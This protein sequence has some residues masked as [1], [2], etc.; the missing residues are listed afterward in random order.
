[1]KS[2]NN[3]HAH[4]H[5]NADMY[6]N[7]FD[8]RTLIQSTYDYN[9]CRFIDHFLICQVNRSSRRSASAHMLCSLNAH[10]FKVDIC[11]H[12]Y[13][14]VCSM[15]SSTILLYFLW[16]SLSS[17]ID[18]S[19]LTYPPFLVVY[20]R[21]FTYTH[22][23]HIH[24]NIFKYLITLCGERLLK[25]LIC[26]HMHIYIYVATH[27]QTG[28]HICFGVYGVK[29]TQIQNYSYTVKKNYYF[30]EKCM[31]FKIAASQQF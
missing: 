24:G 29:I 2:G 7:I 12:V 4:T 10:K 16:Y 28:A 31:Y 27:T 3:K 20:V 5:T 11:V 21:A 17:S 26:Y 30:K 1:M 22:A 6:A 14:C 13:V 9:S 18:E 23:L 19:A 15:V 25:A 8:I